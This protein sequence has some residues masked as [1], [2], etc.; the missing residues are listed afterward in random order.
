MMK[1]RNR[2]LT[3]ATYFGDVVLK[4]PC[5]KTASIMTKASF[6][7]FIIAAYYGY[8]A[9]KSDHYPT[10]HKRQIGGVTFGDQNTLHNR[11]KI[12]AGLGWG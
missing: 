10:W 6:W 7:S 8:I 1:S 12:A 4:G 5:L 2:S 3:I 11:R 9:P